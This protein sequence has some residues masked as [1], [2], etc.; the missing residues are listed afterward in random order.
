MPRSFKSANPFYALLLVAG[1][2]FAFTAMLFGVMMLRESRA[3][4]ATESDPAPA[5]HPLMN[6]MDQYGERALMI[7][8]ALLAIGTVGAIST[9]TYWQNRA[10]R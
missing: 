4:S 6:W 7:E 3:A 8:L 1:I 2:A 9:D 5:E 10:R